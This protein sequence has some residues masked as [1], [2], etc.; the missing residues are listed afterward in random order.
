[1]DPYQQDEANGSAAHGLHALFRFLRVVNRHRL[2]LVGCI[3]A[4]AFL[5]FVRFNRLPKEYSSQMRVMVTRKATSGPSVIYKGRGNTDLSTYREL[6]TSDRVLKDAVRHLDVIPPELSGLT[7]EAL[8]P[9][10]LR[11]M[12]AV[13]ANS[14]DQTVAINCRSQDPR[15]TVSV[16]QALSVASE[17]FLADYQRNIS[18]EL[19]RELESRRE[20]AQRRLTTLEE[21]LLEARR[22]SGDI[23]LSNSG[24]EL[25]P[26]SQRV[27]NINTELTTVRSRRLE[28]ESTLAAANQVVR[29]NSDLT[30]T[31]QKLGDIVGDDILTRVPG[32]TGADAQW[33]KGLREELSKMEA[34]LLALR[35]HFGS[36]HPDVIQRQSKIV[37]QQQLILQ[38]EAEKKNQ[39]LVGVRSPDIGRWLIETLQSELAATRQYES[40]LLQ[41]Y[42]TVETNAMELS[43]KL[44]RIRNLEREAN[45]L[46]ELHTSLLTRLNSMDVDHGGGGFRVAPLSDPLVPSNAS[47]PV[48]SS[49]MSMF[50]FAGAAIGLAIIYV[51]DLLDDRLG[52][53]EEVR[54]N[55]GLPVL[56]V[57]RKLP[58]DEIDQAKIYVHAF[59]QT[60]HAECFRTLKTS[61]TLSGMAT[62]CLAITSTEASEGKTTT[63][64]NL[65]AS[66]AQTGKKTLLIDA[67]M[68]RPGLSRLLELRTV[69]GLSEILRADS[70]IPG[71]CDERV[72]QTEVPLLH[73]LPCGPRILNAGMLLSMPS[74][75]DILD[76]A[77]GQY[78]QVIVDCPPTLPVSDA[79]IVGRFVDGM[80]FLM[81]PDKVHRR[82]VVRA[83][84]QLRNMD[85]KIVGV[86]ANTSLSEDKGSYGYSYGYGYGYGSGYG[87][88]YGHEDDGEEQIEQGEMTGKAA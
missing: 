54:D 67:D 9:Y 26:L 45:T 75:A 80:L 41:E 6:I 65:A 28:L 47:Y 87:N 60:T 72:V 36:R 38:A 29:S 19:I 2:I 22:K 69:G 50:C 86:V 17:K 7:D 35:P 43:D 16:I 70:D 33:L 68:R 52:S 4:A 30:P 24:E 21:R 27:G 51:M 62:K 15:A 44:A 64:V 57:I 85:L 1:M 18:V 12:V 25:H 61:I 23:A 10:V 59:P 40:S 31:L 58:E 53:P 82:N 66:Y 3:G 8:W 74:L 76:W 84:D 79:A 56:G 48:L 81:N 83:V 42:S 78:D 49:I 20:S 73:V 11:T 5:A 46:R 55:L 37:S 14:Q 88:A 77:V 34:E 32:A 39:I 63:T 71:M 13:E